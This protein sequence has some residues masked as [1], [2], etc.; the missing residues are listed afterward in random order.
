[1]KK[2]LILVDIQNDFLPGGSLAVSKSDEILPVVKRLVK[3]PFDLKVAT[4]DWHPPHHYSFASSWGKK[5]GDLISIEGE[6]QILWSDHCV[7]GSFGAE[8]SKELQGEHFHFIAHKGSDMKIDSYSTFFDNRKK[9]STG[10]ETF[11]KDNQV[12]ELYFAGVAT[13]YCVYYSAMDAL[14][15]GFR[16]YVITDGCRG[17]ELFPGDI[18][19]ACLEMKKRG[20]EFITADEACHV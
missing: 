19:R 11:L 20:V 13:D 12:D 14:D 3:M 18:A 4:M 9:R 16:V 10:L 8:L 7:Q 2:A 5:H 15:L 17:I 1:M 6:E